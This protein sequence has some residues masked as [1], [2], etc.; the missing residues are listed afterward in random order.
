MV[1]QCWT[2]LA[3]HHMPYGAEDQRVAVANNGVLYG[4]VD[5]GKCA[6]KC[7]CAGRVAGPASALVTRLPLEAAA[8]DWQEQLETVDVDPDEFDQR[9]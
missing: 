4:A 5:R 7:Q 9:D 3:D 2:W 8:A 1:D 6:F